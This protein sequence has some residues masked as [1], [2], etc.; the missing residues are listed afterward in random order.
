MVSYVCVIISVHLCPVGLYVSLSSRVRCNAVYLYVYVS[1]CI[2]LYPYVC[3][4][5]FVV[6]FSF[7]RLVYV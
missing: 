2:D 3:V 7:D 6:L 1:A 5:L 4:L